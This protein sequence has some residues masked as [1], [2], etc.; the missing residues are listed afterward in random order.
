MSIDFS[1]VIPTF[2]R[3]KQL[4]E[5]IRSVLGQKGVTLEVLVIDDCPDGSAGET[6]EDLREPR[7][8]YLRNPAPTGGIPSVVRNLA[9]PIATGRFVHFLDDDDIV[10]DGHY[11][12][13]MT[14]FENHT[15]IGLV[16]GRIEP[17]GKCPVEQLEHERRYFTKA[18]RAALACSRFG[19]KFAFTAQMLF[20]SPIL[21]CSAGVIRRECLSKVGGFDPRIRLMEDADFYARIM[22]HCGACYLDQLALC[23]RIGSPSLMHSPSPDPAQLEQQRVGRRRMQEKYLKERGVIEFFVLAFFAR[24]ALRFMSRD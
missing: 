17:F 24:T 9:L 4:M 18:A 13:V 19:A 8:S 15:G 6:I 12:N 23:Y 10:P 22:R 1:V 20:D 5:A 14:A 21:V 11:L 2:R 7:V 3:P 16:F